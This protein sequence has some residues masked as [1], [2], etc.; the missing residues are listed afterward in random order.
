MKLVILDRD[1]VINRDT[2]D[3][4]RSAEQWQPLPGSIE[5]LVALHKAGYTVAVATNQSGLAR[6]H[7]DLD[8]LEAMHA[9]LTELV[10]RGGGSLSAIDRK[11]TRLNS[12]H[13]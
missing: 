1:G 5:A 12:S 9:K 4:I 8:D 3:F 11:S 13:V 2:G 6:G 10:E 7:F